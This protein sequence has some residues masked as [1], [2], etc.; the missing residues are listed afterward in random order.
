ML[1]ALF[2]RKAETEPTQKE[3]SVVEQAANGL[4]NKEIARAL[5]I[6]TNT[7]KFHLK[8]VMGKLGARNRTH[9]AMI[10]RE[11]GLLQ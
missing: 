3:I 1:E 9:A 4:Q 2:G 5:H 7:V 6:S 8:R 10:A 11:R